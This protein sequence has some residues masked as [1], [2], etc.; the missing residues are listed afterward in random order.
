M[1]PFS[2]SAVVFDADGTLF[3]TERLGISVWTQAGELLGLPQPAQRYREFIGRSRTDILALMAQLF[4]KDFPGDRFMD[5]CH[6]LATARM[7][8]DGVP[9]KAGAEA[10]LQFLAHR[11]IPT[12]LATSTH[13][14]RTMYRLERC[15]F[16]GYFQAI[17]TGDQ[18]RHSKPDP[19]IYLLACRALGTDPGRT[20]AVEDSHNGIRSAHAAGML[21]VMV[22]DLIPP[23]PELDALCFQKFESLLAL[24]DYLA[25]NL[26]D[27]LT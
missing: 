15:G 6:Q 21:P 24:R 7:E 3:D 18:V 19:E 5:T 2:L 1:K 17:V 25:Q 11:N 27:S 14:D 23:T 22:P 4:G 13:R 16:T 12:A 10:I 8:R 26:Y 20:M 9:L